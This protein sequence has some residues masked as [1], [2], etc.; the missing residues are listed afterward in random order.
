MFNLGLVR[1]ELSKDGDGGK[2][3]TGY[4]EA[5]LRL[6]ERLAPALGRR[7]ASRT[8]FRRRRSDGRPFGPVTP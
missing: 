2:V 3:H 6:Y 5:S 8:V 7:A 4:Q 1:S